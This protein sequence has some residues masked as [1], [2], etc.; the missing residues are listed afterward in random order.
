MRSRTLCLAA[1]A[2]LSVMLWSSTARA[3]LGNDVHDGVRGAVGLGLLGAEIPLII[4]GAIGVRNP[5]LLSLI[6]IVVAGGGAAGGYYMGVASTEASVATL[7]AGL[8]LI[9]PA[10]LL[11][12]YGRSYRSER[13]DD[14][15][16]VDRTEE[17]MPDEQQP[18]DETTDETETEVVGP[19]EGEGDYEIPEPTGDEEG[20]DGASFDLSP[21]VLARVRLDGNLPVGG[22]LSLLADESG[23]R[24]GARLDLTLF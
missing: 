10:A 18:I 1:A 5:W 6:P 23:Q 7:V 17:G 16:F 4:Q 24:R 22:V 12:A 21:A 11:V 15:G 14:E 8:A 20:G 2:A 9:I 3:E 19:E 13:G